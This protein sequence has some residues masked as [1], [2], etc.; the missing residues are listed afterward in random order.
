MGEA[1]SGV[2]NIN[3][4]DI[5][6]D[7]IKGADIKGDDV[8]DVDIQDDDVKGDRYLT[9]DP[10]V[11]RSRARTLTWTRGGAVGLV[12]ALVAVLLTLDHTPPGNQLSAHGTIPVTSPGRQPGIP[13]SSAS[14]SAPTTTTGIAVESDTADPTTTVGR[15]AALPATTTTTGTS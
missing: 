14:A 15:T 5:K 13:S 1:A 6:G 12:V 9:D 10:P 7:D 3:R 4:D 11:V 8:Q 2:E